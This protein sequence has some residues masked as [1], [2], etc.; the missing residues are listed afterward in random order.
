LCVLNSED[1]PALAPANPFSVASDPSVGTRLS[2]L[3]Y[4]DEVRQMQRLKVNHEQYNFFKK[5][6]V[7]VDVLQELEASNKQENLTIKDLRNEIGILKKWKESAILET[8]DKDR[9]AN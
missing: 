5:F 6:L 1:L 3:A 7:S 4:R 9:F 2:E 8:V